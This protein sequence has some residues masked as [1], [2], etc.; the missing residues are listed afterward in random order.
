MPRFK[1]DFQLLLDEAAASALA[2]LK[3]GHTLTLVL[4]EP[5]AIQPQVQQPSEEPQEVG[6]EGEGGAD[7]E[8]GGSKPTPTST[9]TSASASAA[10]AVIAVE[11]SSGKPLGNK[12]TAT[13]AT[14]SVTATHAVIS[15]ESS[16]GQLLG[17]VPAHV[18]A[19]LRPMLAS[20]GAAARYRLTVRSLKREKGREDGR[21]EAVLLRL[22]EVVEPKRGAAGEDG[23]V[24]QVLLR[25]E[26]VL[27]TSGRAA[28]EWD[29]A[30]GPRY[31][32]LLCEHSLPSPASWSGISI[33]ILI[34]QP[35][36]RALL[37]AHAC[38]HA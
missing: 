12:A 11:S 6:A 9:H 8:E 36:L 1:L 28:G 20:P 19:K 37:M 2:P 35:A 18:A 22:E 29:A 33:P 13:A 5:A 21:V 38:K 17:S 23:R 7:E 30:W 27:E 34:F 16:S 31:P 25:L 32:P 10:H 26:E 3:A 4:R 15:V 24:E 14:S